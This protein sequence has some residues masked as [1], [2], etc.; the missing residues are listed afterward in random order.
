MILRDAQQAD[1]DAILAL[2]AGEVDKTSPMDAERLAHLH[3]IAGHRRV[4]VVDGAVA[5][6]VLAMRSGAAYHNDNFR[7]FSARYPRFLYVDR[8]VVSS[9]FSGRGIGSALYDDLLDAARR[10]ADAHVVCEYNIEPPNPASAK[11]HRKYGFA[12]VGML[13]HPDTGKRVSMQA[14]LL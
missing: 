6:F 12:E 2:N 5:G 8:I 1:F 3:D 13:A 4:A 11:F 10:N 7:W 14:R 9:V